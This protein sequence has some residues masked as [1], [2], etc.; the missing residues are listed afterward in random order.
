MFKKWVIGS[1]ILAGVIVVMFAGLS[2][3]PAQGAGVSYDTRAGKLTERKAD[4]LNIVELNGRKILEGT[5][6]EV[7]NLRGADV[8]VVAAI[9]NVNCPTGF[10]FVTLQEYDKP[11]VSD[12]IP[13]CYDAKGEVRQEG[14][15]I[16]LKFRESVGT[17]AIYRYSGG[18][19]TKTQE[20]SKVGMTDDQCRTAYKVY[21]EK[22]KGLTSAMVID[23]HL[24]FYKDALNV[25]QFF[26][27]CQQAGDDT[28]TPVSYDDFKGRVC[29][30]QD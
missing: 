24:Y 4:D 30:M 1:A 17:Y 11:Q 18:R 12:W 8:A 25:D 15:D 10:N 5:I 23:R 26:N 14:Q 20:M 7:F 22:C 3:A 29:K 21:T 27:L 6:R 19:V 2:E 13:A 16:V 28:W 9:G